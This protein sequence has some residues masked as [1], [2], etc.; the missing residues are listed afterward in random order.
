LSFF[1]LMEMLYNIVKKL[2]FKR[3]LGVTVM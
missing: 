1:V 2:R 3:N